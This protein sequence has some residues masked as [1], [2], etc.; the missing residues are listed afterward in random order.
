MSTRG[1]GRDQGDQRG[2]PG[3]TG[4]KIPDSDVVFFRKNQPVSRR[5][6]F[7]ALGFLRL[8]DKKNRHETLKKKNKRPMNASLGAVRH[9]HPCCRQH[10]QK[11]SYFQKTQKFTASLKCTIDTCMAQHSAPSRRSCSHSR[12]R[13]RCRPATEMKPRRQRDSRRDN[14]KKGLCCEMC[15]AR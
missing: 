8:M 14:L 2:G 4:F 7:T 3:W 11:F 10:V 1:P 13:R 9:I 5:S 15:L 6:S 12:R